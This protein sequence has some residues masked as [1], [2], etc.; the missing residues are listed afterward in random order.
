M[1][2]NK[3]NEHRINNTDIHKSTQIYTSQH[4]Y[5]QGNT[6]IHKTTQI[7]TSRKHYNT[8]K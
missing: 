2:N 1:N 5:T 6:D 8:V 3:N 7:Y 4:R